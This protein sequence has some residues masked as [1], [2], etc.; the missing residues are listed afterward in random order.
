M[1]SCK[2]RWAMLVTRRLALEFP[3][4]LFDRCQRATEQIP[5]DGENSRRALH[6]QNGSRNRFWRT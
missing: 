1:K 3:Q 5:V 4:R 6:N 2:T